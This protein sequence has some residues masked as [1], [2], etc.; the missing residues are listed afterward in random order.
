MKSSTDG[1]NSF[2]FSYP[3]FRRE[4]AEIDPLRLELLKLLEAI[5]MKAK[6]VMIPIVAGVAVWWITDLAKRY[7]ANIQAQNTDLNLPEIGL[8]ERQSETWA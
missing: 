2:F 8:L 3:T 5:F 4:F 1:K 7:R 6:D